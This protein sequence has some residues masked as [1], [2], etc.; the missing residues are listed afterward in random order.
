MITAVFSDDWLLQRLVLKGG[1]ALNLVHGIGSRTSVDIDLSAPS[2][3]G[4]ADALSKRLEGHLM[5]RF[6]L[7]GFHLFDYQ[8]IGRGRG[9]F[10]GYEVIFK[11]IPIERLRALTDDIEAMRREASEVAPRNLR[12]FKIQI[13][14]NEFC[15]AKSEFE[16]EHYLIYVY[17]PEAI[18]IEKVR[19]ICQQMPAYQHKRPTPRARDFY[20]IWAIESER[21]IDIAHYKYNWLFRAIFEAKDV[22]LEWIASI[23][24]TRPFHAE[25]WP[26]VVQSVGTRELQD[27]D[28]YFD[29]LCKKL[30]LLE[31]L[32]VE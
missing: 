16:L 25:D 23:P 6:R 26:S 8:L 20:D 13:S 2:D 4:A 29:Y 15:D 14:L 31:T 10:A 19:A 27:F 22:P 5:S 11:I 21:S 32:W 17:T 30:D 12:N 3:L 28:Y 1:N 9:K 24:E 18:A 7:A